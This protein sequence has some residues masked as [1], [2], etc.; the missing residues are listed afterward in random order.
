MIKTINT[1]VVTK[2]M[3]DAQY[4]LDGV[5]TLSNPLPLDCLAGIFKAM[6]EAAPA[7]EPVQSELLEVVLAMRDWIDAVPQDTQLP[8]MPGFSRD[9]ANSVIDAALK[10]EPAQAVPVGVIEQVRKLTYKGYNYH[11]AE[12]YAQAIKDAVKLLEADK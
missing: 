11:I 1:K 4:V 10:R 12:G 7:V 8:A 5:T 6:A 2:A 9:W 3:I